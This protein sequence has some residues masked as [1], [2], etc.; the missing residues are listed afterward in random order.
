MCDSNYFP[1]L[2]LSLECNENV[3]EYNEIEEGKE[4]EIL[5]GGDGEVEMEG[6]KEIFLNQNEQIEAA[7]LLEKTFVE[8]NI[9]LEEV[10]CILDSLYT[11]KIE[12]EQKTSQKGGKTYKHCN[13]CGCALQHGG[14]GSTW[15]ELFHLGVS[16]VCSVPSYLLKKTYSNTK[17]LLGWVAGKVAVKLCQL[18][19]LVV[20]SL[21]AMKGIPFV[22]SWLFQYIIPFA[23]KT[24]LSIASMH[25]V[26]V[27]LTILI[28]YLFTKIPVPWYDSDSVPKITKLKIAQTAFSGISGYAG[29]VANNSICDE[30]GEWFNNLF[31]QPSDLADVDKLKQA[32]GL[33]D[34]DVKEILKREFIASAQ[35]PVA[36]RVEPQV[37]RHEVPRVDPREVP[38]VDLREV[39]RAVPRVVPPAAPV[40]QQLAERSA[41]C[42][43]THPYMCT[44]NTKHKNWCI[45][46]PEYCNMSLNLISTK[47]KRKNPKTN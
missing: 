20:V 6:K 43:T 46:E 45:E 41:R 38:R 7:A 47:P 14:A 2:S 3:I 32:M 15:S 19:S 4:D 25:V 24:V 42:Y 29:F 26:F 31:K 34:E 22:V 30:I 36:P 35:T 5:K 37:H 28:V 27:L 16:H 8:N 18:L 33:T 23:A 1:F 12:I 9:P 44:N 11:K 21:A 17:H 40:L 39:P 13:K 10:A